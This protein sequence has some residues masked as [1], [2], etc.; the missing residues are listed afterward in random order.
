MKQCIY[1]FTFLLSLGA[2][3]QVAPLELVSLFN[4][5]MPALKVETT[6]AG[7][8]AMK[9]F[10]CIQMTHYLSKKNLRTEKN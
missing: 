9:P 7:K 5:H 6:D 1:I 4:F 2:R 8:V 3:A 10:C